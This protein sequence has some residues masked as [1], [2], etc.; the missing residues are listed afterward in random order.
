MIDKV[1]TVPRS[2]LGQRVGKLGDEGMSA[3]N[4]ALLI[5]LGMA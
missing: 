3:A 4:K 2:K 1:T 5:F